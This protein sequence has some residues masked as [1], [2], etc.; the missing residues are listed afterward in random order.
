MLDDMPPEEILAAVERLVRE[1]LDAAELRGPPVDA[2][3]LARQYLP[4]EA[5]QPRRGRR[6]SEAD[7]AM[8][9]E[10][11][12]WA[13][14]Q[15]V[16]RHLRDVLFERLG[17]EAEAGRGLAGSSLTNLFAPRL[18]LPADWFAADAAAL[19]FDVLKLKERYPTCTHETIALRLLD[20]PEPCIITV[21]DEGRVVR[22]RSNA[23]PVRRELEP[24]EQKC[25]HA[26]SRSGRPRVVRADNWTVQGWP[27][28][29][30]SGARVIL[31]SVVE[32]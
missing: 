2:V 11:K 13:A 8:T 31:R 7:D 9:E 29:M 28:P 27:I 18:L 30:T 14:A 32:V 12:Q 23:W 22:R 5:Q 6:R 19:D 4:P 10:Q 26:I 1:L 21:L 25:Q 15:Q 24:V 3:A 16:G 20:L 17:V